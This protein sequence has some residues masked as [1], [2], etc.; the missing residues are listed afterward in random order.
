MYQTYVTIVYAAT[1]IAL[2]GYVVYW[3]LKM[4]QSEREQ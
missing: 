3:Y 1:F 4:K 2:I